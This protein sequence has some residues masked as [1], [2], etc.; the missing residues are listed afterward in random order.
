MRRTGV[1]LVPAR[2]LAIGDVIAHDDY[3]AEVLRGPYPAKDLFGRRMLGFWLRI[4]S[5][6]DRSGDEGEYQFGESG[7]A[8]VRFEHTKRATP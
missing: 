2:R 5:G 4:V 1:R 6:P 7:L 8:S 3:G